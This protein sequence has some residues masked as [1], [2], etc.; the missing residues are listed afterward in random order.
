MEAYRMTTM[1]RFKII[2][3][4]PPVLPNKCAV[5]G[6]CSADE[7]YIDFGLDLD[8][9]GTVYICLSNCF[10]EAANSIEYYSPAQHRV[11]LERVE[12]F[13][14]ENNRLKD[15]VEA[16]RNVMGNLSN[17]NTSH[18]ISID[19]DLLQPKPVQESESID[20]QSPTDNTESEN[21][22]P[23]SIE[24]TNEQRST[25]VQRD[26]SLDSLLDEI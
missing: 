25:D 2:Y 26:D 12:L 8:F 19:P 11:A 14:K 22:E 17:I 9:Y 16:Y 18:L 10:V 1:G 24:Q 20:L 23:R 6:T 13:R 5:C 21:S 15:I 4:N 3:G 7:S